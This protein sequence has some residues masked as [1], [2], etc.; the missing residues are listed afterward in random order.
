MRWLMKKLGYVPA[1]DLLDCQQALV[2]LH[3]RVLDMERVDGEVDAAINR[4][5]GLTRRTTLPPISELR[6]GLEAAVY[7]VLERAIVAEHALS[8]REVA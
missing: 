5:A 1:K 6:T 8:R 4:A 3:Q 7:R 2:I